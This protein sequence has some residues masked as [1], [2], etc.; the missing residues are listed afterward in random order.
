MD[1]CPHLAASQD[2]RYEECERTTCGVDVHIWGE[3]RKCCPGHSNS[4]SRLGNHGKTSGRFSFPLSL[5]NV[6]KC[7]WERRTNIDSKSFPGMRL[8]IPPVRWAWSICGVDRHSYSQTSL[9]HFSKALHCHPQY[10][11]TPTAGCT[12]GMVERN[13]TVGV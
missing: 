1:I 5:V 13:Q 3:L 2:L 6:H 11:L 7:Y 4:T 10:T 12:V 9:P 8:H